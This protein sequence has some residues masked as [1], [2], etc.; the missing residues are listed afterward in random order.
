[1]EEADKLCDRIAIIDKSKIIALDTPQNLKSQL[2]GETI[3]IE[4]SDNKLLSEKLKDNKLVDNI[5][6]TDKE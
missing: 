6:E 2:S 3:I 1:M 5:M 4:S